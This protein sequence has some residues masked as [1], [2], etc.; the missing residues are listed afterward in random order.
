MKPLLIAA[1]AALLA[2]CAGQV[3]SQPATDPGETPAD[4]TDYGPNDCV[5]IYRLNQSAIEVHGVSEPSIGCMAF[6]AAD[7]GAVDTRNA[8]VSVEH[9]ATGRP[10][11]GC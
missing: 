11:C 7:T 9:F 5:R 3:E 4:V 10:E 1:I 2:G 8:S 6:V